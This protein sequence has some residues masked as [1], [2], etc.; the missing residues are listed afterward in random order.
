MEACMNWDQIQGNWKQWKGKAQSQ[1]GQLTGD[2][3]DEIE[4]DRTRLEGKIQER[5]GTTK[6][7]AREAVDSWMAKH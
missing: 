5:Y 3:L 2:D 7:E 4:G 6:E 1:W